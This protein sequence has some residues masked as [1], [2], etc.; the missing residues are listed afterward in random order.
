[1]GQTLLTPAQQTAL[2]FIGGEDALK[3][4]YLSGGTAL[5]AFHLGHRLSDDLDFFT[6]ETIPFTEVLSAVEGLREVL[7]AKRVRMDHIHDRHL[8]FFQLSDDE[9][10]MEFSRYPFDVLEPPVEHPEYGVR[11]DGLRDIAANKLAALLDRFD[12]KDFVDLYFLLETRT[13]YEIRQDAQE[14]FGIKIGDLFLGSGFSKV[15]RVEAL[16]K[17]I[18]SLS[19][20]ELKA[21]FTD[22][23]RSLEQGVIA[24]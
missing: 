1:M 19:I 2:S 10:K 5:S 15:R 16:P 23:A 24:D 17:M 14:K 6:Q 3:G 20:N 22:L 13:L 21:F 7:K 11:I 12:P 18:K 9:L 8:F 4:F